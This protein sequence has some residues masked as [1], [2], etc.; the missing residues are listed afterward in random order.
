MKTSEKQTRFV[1]FANQRK[2]NT[3]RNRQED[4]PQ[5]LNEERIISSYKP[6]EKVYYFD[7]SAISLSYGQYNVEKCL[8]VLGI[9]IAFSALFIYNYYD[10]F[11]SAIFIIFLTSAV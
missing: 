3:D 8:V 1:T 6:K 7:N 5:D 2:A 9:L 4:F 11:S 10:S